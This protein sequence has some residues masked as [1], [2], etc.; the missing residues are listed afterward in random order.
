MVKNLK[1]SGVGHLELVR[2]L[3]KRTYDYIGEL[4][5][6]VNPVAFCEGGFL[7]GHLN[8][9]DKIKSI[10]PPMTRVVADLAVQVETN[11]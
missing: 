2:G 9:D 1:I 7:G 6:S 8:P 4:H 5:A 11:G 3:H 10:L